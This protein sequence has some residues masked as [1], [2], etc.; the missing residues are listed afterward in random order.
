M[1]RPNVVVFLTDGHRADMLGCC[2]NSLLRTPHVDEFAAAST[3]FRRAFCSHSVC[4]PTRASIFTGRYPHV[5]GVWANGVPLPRAEV[6]LPQV[7][8][9]DGYA[10]CAAGKVHFEPQQAYADGLAPALGEAD[11]PYYGFQE[12]HLS[13][14]CLGHEYLT[15]VA[16]EFPELTARA[17]RRD[18]MPEPAHDLHWITTQ[19]IGFIERQA[20]A[21]TPFF[22]SCSF[23]ELCPPSNPPDTF[24]GRHAPDAVPIPELRPDDL[25][26]K[27][28]FYRQCYEGYRRRGR[29]PD[30][31]TLRR[32]VAS[33]YDQMEFIDKQFGRVLAAL[34]RLGVREDTVV[35][36]TADHGL[37]LNDHYQWRHGPFLFDQVVNVP[38]IWSVPGRQRR[39]LVTDEIVEGI[40]I[41]PTV[42][43]VCGVARPPGVQGTSLVPLIHG[44]VGATGK[45]SA[46]LQER[47]AP[48]LAAR[49]LDPAA[50]N[51][52]AVRT[53][54][55]KLIHYPGKPYGELYDLQ[56]DPGEFDNLWDDPGYGKRRREME[57]LLLDRLAEAEDPLPARAYEW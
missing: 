43:E 36:F 8:A 9:E 49:G 55:W 34:D 53:H 23:H 24:R 40:D 7:L 54:A 25:K 26:K 30:E 39:G 11:L 29:Q 13:E 33:T 27:P 32:Y 14:N 22:C 5:H 44:T 57:C 46:L 38:M 1:H 35:L 10:T 3:R 20:S 42:L 48:D 31:E 51:Q 47:E 21:G 6:T 37:S 52:V 56:N 41:M 18:R 12:V 2:G 28:P 15:F 19:A 4:M 45:E 17:R 50:V 16:D